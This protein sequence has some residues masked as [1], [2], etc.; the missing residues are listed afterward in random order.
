MGS[1]NALHT[2]EDP[3]APPPQGKLSILVHCCLQH[4]FSFFFF[5][6]HV[7]RLLLKHRNT[8]QLK[9]STSFAFLSDLFTASSQ[10]PLTQFGCLKGKK[11][12]KGREKETKQNHKTNK[13]TKN[14]TKARKEKH[15]KEENNK[16][17]QGLEVPGHHTGF[18]I[19]SPTPSPS[20]HSFPLK[21]RK[22]KRKKK[23]KEKRMGLVLRG[24]Y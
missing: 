22:E 18:K 12:K 9:T 4:F 1:P 6:K 7:L 16:L 10:N 14:E 23:E 15:L 24:S 19:N 21:K 2:L 13:Q 3:P 11:K 17:P 8:E 20:T 5:L